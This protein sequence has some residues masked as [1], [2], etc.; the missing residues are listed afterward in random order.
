MPLLLVKKIFL[1]LWS[2]LHLRIPTVYGW[3]KANP[4]Y[5]IVL[6]QNGPR[7]LYSGPVYKQVG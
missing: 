6:Q 7:Y 2:S 5:F 3:G 1:Q 4:V